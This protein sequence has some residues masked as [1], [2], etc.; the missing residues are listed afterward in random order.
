MLEKVSDFGSV[1]EF[2]IFSTSY[3]LEKELLFGE[4]CWNF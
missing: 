2:N 3:L 4:K 1:L